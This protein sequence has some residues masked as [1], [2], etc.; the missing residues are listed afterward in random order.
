LSVGFATLAPVVL[1]GSSDNV[2]GA[3]FLAT[4]TLGFGGVVGFDGV[5]G[6]EGLRWVTARVLSV[7]DLVGVEGVDAADDAL[8]DDFFLGG[9][10]SMSSSASSACLR[11]AG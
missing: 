8:G 1:G 6:V 5:V 10:V 11:E 4:E 2:E 3:D 7:T 9:E